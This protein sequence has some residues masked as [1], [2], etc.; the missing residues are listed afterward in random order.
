MKKHL[1]LSVFVFNFIYA[2][3]SQPVLVNIGVTTLEATTLY[4]CTDLPW[5]LKMGPGDSLW[6]TTREGRV[7]R[8]STATGAANVMLDY[9]NK[10]WAS[11]ES[12]MLG[13]A[14]DPDFNTHPYVY[15]VYTY[16]N[17]SIHQERLSRFTYE[18]NA[19]SSSSEFVLVEGI[20]AASNH[21]GSRL[22]IL[23]DKT[24][25]MTTGDAGIQALPQD[26]N[27]LSGKILRLNLDG[28]IP[29]NNPFPG[30]KVFTYGHRNGQGL[31]QHPNGTIY[32]TEN[33]P[34]NN[35]EFQ[36]IQIGRNYG[37]PNVEGYCDNDIAGETVF[38]TNHSVKEPLVSWLPAPGGTWAPSDMV[39]YN[40]SRIPEFQNSI[41]VTFLK[42]SK[43]RRI[44]LNAAGGITG[45]QDFFVN[46]WGRL[47]D[48]TT[49]NDGTIY[50]VTNTIP[51]RVIRLRNTAVVPV[52]I[53]NY[54]ASCRNKTALVNW[55]SQT[56]INNKQY[57]VYRSVNGIDFSLAGTVK[58]KENNS[59]NALDYSFADT[60]FSGKR[61]FY[62]LVSEDA[63]GRQTSWGVVSTTCG[64]SGPV[65]TLLPNPTTGQA[66]L[67]IENAEAP[68]SVTVYN[69]DGKIVYQNK[70]ALGDVRLPVEEWVASVYNVMV[71]DEKNNMLLNE[72]LVVNK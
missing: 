2:S 7:Y 31:I 40:S 28:T 1:L 49:D 46:Q 17:G 64:T 4:A 43:L 23:P 25:L 30:S 32:E 54:N 61:A 58:R 19:L 45:E 37:W 51:Y 50:I 66:R 12:G 21:N 72:K 56:E 18:N 63:D 65:F 59:G 20:P 24:I 33:G 42:A 67:R 57:L 52:I 15:I 9:R 34:G 35:D 62:K 3:F 10:I 60:A 41:L 39:W 38:C 53:N 44:Y 68:L 48:I 11:G 47:R 13:M 22:L 14:L 69:M 36:V 26:K 29:A 71:M 16:T 5:E 27:S 6:M 8:M 70:R 55:R